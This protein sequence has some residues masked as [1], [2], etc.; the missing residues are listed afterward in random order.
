MTARN[1]NSYLNYL[2]KSV[3]ECNY[4]IGKKTCSY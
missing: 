1:S 2:D 4:D 3:D